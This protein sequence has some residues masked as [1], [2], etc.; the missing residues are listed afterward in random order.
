MDE[1]KLEKL[2]TWVKRNRAGLC[3]RRRGCVHGKRYSGFSRR[4]RAVSPA[5]R[6]SA[7][8]H[9]FALVLCAS[10]GNLLR[11]LPKPHALSERKAQCRPSK[12]SLEWGTGWKL[13]AVV[14][15]NIDGLHQMA[16]SRNVYELHGSVHRN[17]CQ[18]C[19]ARYTLAQNAD[20]RRRA[21]M[22]QV[23]RA[24]EAGRRAL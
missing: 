24:G 10:P 18:K 5:V 4:G 11:F 6:L 19:G 23:R 15:Q 22:P 3:F 13:L 1:Q 12:N 2:Q 20:A 16:G 17:T 8:N 21:Q 7:G 14:T 9:H